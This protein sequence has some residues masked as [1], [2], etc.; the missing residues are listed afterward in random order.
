MTVSV[1]TH[2]AKTHL[3]ELLKR[4]REGEVI[5]ISSAGTPVAKLVPLGHAAPRQPGGVPFGL[6]DRFFAPLPAAELTAWER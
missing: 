4:V 6:D 2:Y 5:T 1:N 3:S